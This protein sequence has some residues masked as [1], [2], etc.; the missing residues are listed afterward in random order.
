MVFGEEER[1]EELFSGIREKEGAVSLA[2]KELAGFYQRQ[3]T[4]DAAALLPKVRAELLREAQLL[5]GLALRF[6]LT[7]TEPI[8][9]SV[10]L[11]HLPR[12]LAELFL[13]FAAEKPIPPRLRPLVIS[14]AAVVAQ[15]LEPALLEE[16]FDRLQP[17]DE[18]ADAI[19]ERLM[20]IELAGANTGGSK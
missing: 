1:A 12:E 5:Y 16:Y 14:S 17:T 15:V 7:G 18:E 2:V 9:R 4:G 10:L 6:V 13:L 8:P 11:D 3:Q 20:G 19:R